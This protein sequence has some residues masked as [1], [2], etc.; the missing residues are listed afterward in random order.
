MTFSTPNVPAVGLL[1]GRATAELKCRFVQVSNAISY[2]F[3]ALRPSNAQFVNYAEFAP[4]TPAP[5]LR[6]VA[7]TG[8]LLIGFFVLG[9]GIWSVVAPLKSAAI[10]SGIVE[11][12]SSRK[13]IQHL[14]GGIV[15]QILVKNGDVVSS[16]QVLIRLDDIKPRTES[17]SLSGQFWDAKVRQARLL[18]EQAGK[19]KIVLSDEIQAAASTNPEIPEILTGQQKIFETRRDVARSQ[20][21]VIQTKMAQIRQEIVG[22]QA[23]Q[24]ALSIRADIVHKE[25]DTITALVTKKLE[26][27][28][29][30]LDLMRENADI[31]G[32]LGETAAQIARAEQT[33]S[34]AQADLLKFE[35]D[36]QN[37]IAQSL[38]ETESQLLQLA[39]RMQAVDDQLSRTE[40]RAPQD[41][42]I[43]DLRIHTAG[44]VVGAGEPLLDLVPKEDRL[45]VTARIRPEDINVV[46]VGLPARVHLLPYDQ[47]RVPLLSGTVAYVSADRL[48]D[49][50]S[51][52][53]Y[54]AATIRVSDEQLATMK[55]VTLVPGMPVQALIETGQS[56]VA[57]YA[58]RPV[59]DSFG[60]AFRED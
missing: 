27:Q 58:L 23:Q 19:D 3:V 52:Q 53:S 37:E 31:N 60:R 10:A 30:L 16:G 43:T 34:E 33:I 44:G 38:R 9:F 26:K 51:G 48:V 57:L 49:K 14:E 42:V 13:T 4:A 7:W 56:T 47:R 5:R 15:R 39:E 28:S 41:G 45:I 50:Q 22:F 40:I 2:R 59:L 29:R 18:S 36:R 6:R 35:S 17:N 1:A 24:A 11:P 55:D 46:H 25:I 12:E 20:I 21:V 8:N 54:Y 32:Q